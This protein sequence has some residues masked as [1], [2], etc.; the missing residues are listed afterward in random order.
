MESNY[1]LLS[2]IYRINDYLTNDLGLKIKIRSHPYIKTKD[3]LN[4][5]KWQKLPKSWEWSSQEL[6]DDLREKLL[7][8]Y[9]ALCGSN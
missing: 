2:K 8:S 3:I 6:E 9:N 7:C 4:N 1:E 5:L